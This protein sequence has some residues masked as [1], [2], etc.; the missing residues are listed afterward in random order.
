MH[1]MSQT[2][3][4]TSIRQQEVLGVFLHKPNAVRDP[5][6]GDLMLYFTTNFADGRTVCNCAD[7]SNTD[8][9]DGTHAEGATYVS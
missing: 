3:T 6:T 4:G 5:M 1:A 2:A 9:C 7:G 8:S